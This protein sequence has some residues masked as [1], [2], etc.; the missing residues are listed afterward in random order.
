MDGEYNYFSTYFLEE[1]TG[2]GR[3][4]EREGKA[5][6]TSFELPQTDFILCVRRLLLLLALASAKNRL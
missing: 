4:T 2:E 1:G 6:L 5:R 3:G